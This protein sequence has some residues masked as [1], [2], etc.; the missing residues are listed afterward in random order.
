VSACEYCLES[1]CVCTI[2]ATALAQAMLRGSGPR[3]GSLFSGYG[4]LDMGVMAAIGGS[5]AWH[6]EFDKAPSKIL[7]HHWPDVPNYGDVTAVDWS[8]VE[9]VDVITGGSPCQDLS[10]AGKRQGMTEGT[11]SNLWVAMREAIAQL[12]PGLVVWENVRGA[13]SAEATSEVEPCPGCVGDG[14]GV[15]L[16]ALGRVVGDLADLGYVGRIR[17]LRAADVGAPHGRF[18]FFLA[19][20]PAGDTRWFQYG[21]GHAT[22]DA[23]RLRRGPGW[24]AASGEAPSG[25]PSTVTSGSD[26]VSGSALLPHLMPTPRATDGTKGG[27]NQRGSSGDLMLPSAVTLLPTPAVNDMGEG[28]TPE[29]WDEW[30]AKMQAAHGNGNGHGKSLAI[31]AQRLLQ[32]PSVADGLGG[33]LNR[34]GARSGEQLLPGQAKD[35]HGQ[36]WGIYADAIARWEALTRPAPAPTQPSKK[37]TPQLSPA[38]SEWLMGLP[39]GHVTGVPGLSRNDMLKALGNGVVPQQAAAALRLM[40]STQDAAA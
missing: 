25:R 9:P 33:H 23:Q 13:A 32:T 16:R 12:R 29:A 6:V 14:S 10:H 28:K 26:R 37:G 31:E 34:S 5:V 39:A 7:A 20:Y 18:R 1:P 21:D 8:Q 3:I 27:P 22:K 15:N 40:L 36:E 4:G 11:R 19:A 38:F 17:G 24:N 30:T 2:D 35:M